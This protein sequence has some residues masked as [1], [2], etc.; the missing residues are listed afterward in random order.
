MITHTIWKEKPK[1]R[2]HT[3]SWGSPEKQE[4]WYQSYHQDTPKP[5]VRLDKLEYAK[6]IEANG[7]QKG[8][9]IVSKYFGGQ[10][11]SNLYA[12]AAYR[13]VDVQE[14]HY[15]A[16]YGDDGPRYLS[17]ECFVAPEGAFKRAPLWVEGSKF[18]RIPDPENLK[19]SPL[20]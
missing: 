2:L 4:P 14:I 6:H 16:E 10:D 9:V 19:T 11:T 8:D 20:R 5:P 3:S 13:V 17:V 7:I 1:R 15:M 18:R 12:T